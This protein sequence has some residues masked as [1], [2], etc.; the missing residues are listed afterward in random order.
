[1]LT[2]E[3]IESLGMHPEWQCVQN[4]GRVEILGWDGELFTVAFDDACLEG[5]DS[6]AYKDAELRRIRQL[7]IADRELG[8]TKEDLNR[9]RWLQ[10]GTFERATQEARNASNSQM[11]CYLMRDEI[12]TVAKI[13]NGDVKKKL[14]ALLSKSYPSRLSDKRT[15]EDAQA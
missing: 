7:V 13:A 11:Y 3:E 8:E 9:C 10:E 14:E 2:K 15:N 1:M 5:S 6:P 12:E 4:G